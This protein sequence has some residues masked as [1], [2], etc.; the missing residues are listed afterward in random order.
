MT[1]ENGGYLMGKW[2]NLVDIMTSE[3]YTIYEC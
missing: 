3:L 1:L 2:L